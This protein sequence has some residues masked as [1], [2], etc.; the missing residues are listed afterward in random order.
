MTWQILRFTIPVVKVCSAITALAAH[1]SYPPKDFRLHIYDMTSPPLPH[2]KR[3]GNMRRSAIG[4]WDDI[5]HDHETTLK[6]LKTVQGCHGSW[7]IT[8]SHL[9]PDNERRVVVFP[10]SNKAYVIVG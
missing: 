10:P 4:V 8:D 5:E 7:T 6:V 1:D 2:I 3:P 9:S